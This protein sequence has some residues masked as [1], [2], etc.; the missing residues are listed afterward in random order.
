[1]LHIEANNVMGVPY[2]SSIQ[3]HDNVAMGDQARSSGMRKRRLRRKDYLP[4][5]DDN[6]G[7]VDNKTCIGLKK[8]SCEIDTGGYAEHNRKQK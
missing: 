2:W 5:S 6:F 1:M 7:K 8:E 4:I 3:H